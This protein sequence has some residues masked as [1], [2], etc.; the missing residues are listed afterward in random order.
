LALLV[1]LAA[2]VTTAAAQSRPAEPLELART[3][4]LEKVEGRIDHMTVDAAKNRLFVAALESN[5]LEV[6]EL[7]EGRRKRRIE[8]M[9]QIQG[10]RWLPNLS[11][12][13]A[14]TGGDGKCRFFD[15]SLAPIGVVESLPDADNVRFDES[16]NRVYVGYGSGALAVIDA[17]KMTLAGTIDLSGHP[18]SFQLE[19]A[20]KR[21]FVNVPIAGHVAVVDRDKRQVVA[22]WPLGEMK[23][24]FP[25]ALDEANH[26]LFVV[27]RKPARLLVIDTESGKTAATLECADD[28]DDV[29]H[30]AARG[31]LY[32][33]G[34]AGMV[35]VYERKADGSW[36]LRASVPTAA[37]ARTSFF[38][39][40]SSRLWVAVPHRNAQKA[41]LREFR[42]P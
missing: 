26:Q 6:V 39:P 41:E 18:E 33:S 17:V 21:I 9:P 32:V 2:S 42:L 20:G 7:G 14:T 30:D 29:F 40:A 1:A 25:M 23:Q 4:P 13:A 38:D 10:V 36:F 37:G 28:A 27:C 19:K 16:K 22:T 11:R 5:S 31:R 8:K 12:L 24:N 3:I 15:D 35:C 34:G